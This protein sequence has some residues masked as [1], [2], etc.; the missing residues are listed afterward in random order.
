MLSHY[1]LAMRTRLRLPFKVAISLHKGLPNNWPSPQP[2]RS[3]NSPLNKKNG[4]KKH[5]RFDFALNSS[6]NS[7]SQAL[8]LLPRAIRRTRT[9]A[10]TSLAMWNR[11]HNTKQGSMLFFHSVSTSNPSTRDRLL[12]LITLRMVAIMPIQRQRQRQRQRQ[13]QRQRQL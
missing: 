7:E 1:L 2:Q 13:G 3:R 9:T 6:M 4:V 8:I 12:L 11:Q 10:A 5:P